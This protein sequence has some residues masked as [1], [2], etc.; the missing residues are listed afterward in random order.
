MPSAKRPSCLP[1]IFLRINP[2]LARGVPNRKL[3]HPLMN[4]EPLEPRIAPAAITITGKTAIWTDFDGDI[5]TMKWTSD[6]APTFTTKDRGEGLMVARI[7]LDTSHAGASFSITVKRGGTFG[8]GRVELG[9]LD[10]TGVALGNWSGPKAAISEVDFGVPNGQGALSFLCGGIGQTKITDSMFA[11]AMGDD[12]SEIRGTVGTLKIA[13]DIGYGGLSI[14]SA[15][16]G[17]HGPITVTGSLRGL[18]PGGS[19]SDGNFSIGGPGKSV[20]IGGSIINAQLLAFFGDAFE[21]VTIGGDIVNT[22]YPYSVSSSGNFK[23]VTIKGSIFGASFQAMG[24]ERVFVGGSLVARDGCQ[25]S[26]VLSV[27]EG[28]TRVKSVTVKGG[29][30]GARFNDWIGDFGNTYVGAGAIL[31]EG[32][33]DSISVGG[34]IHGGSI[35]NSNRAV[36]GGIQVSGN[37]GSLKVGGGLY[38]TDSGPVFILA[39]GAA[40]AAGDFNAIG[41]IGIK[42]DATGAYIAAGTRLNNQ[43]TMPLVF[44]N[45]G[46]DAG[47][48]SVFIGGNFVNSNIFAG[49]KDGGSPGVNGV[50]TLA[51]GD[52]AR[53]AKLG[54]VLVKGFLLSDRA[55]TIFAGFTA[56]VIASI[57]V[58]GRKVFSAGDGQRNFDTFLIAREL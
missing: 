9:H 47:I 3:N 57:T 44:T 11:G 17:K 19:N 12:K 20:T 42:G 22:T 23:T 50:D 28:S 6:S 16:L 51:V 2:E 5:V 4:I 37:L 25:E 33:V 58:A 26:G 46:P 43:G 34:S 15:T 29:L 48:G 31:V 18:L 54:P 39:G 7:E 49:V 56:D 40:P 1:E 41:K 10:A 38:G 53:T 36:N 21:R 13:G 52:A 30:Y 27:T 32:S 24:S 55:S 35:V 14:L 8:D 45:P